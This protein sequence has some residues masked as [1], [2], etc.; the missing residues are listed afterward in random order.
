MQVRLGTWC[1]GCTGEPEGTVQWA[2][3][4]TTFDAAPYVMTITNL[5]ID[6]ANPAGS[7]IYSDMSGSDSSIATGGTIALPA[8]NDTIGAGAP[9]ASASLSQISVPAQSTSSAVA[10]SSAQGNSTTT[11]G[12]AASGTPTT[13]N[14]ANN[15]TTG[16]A[17]NVGPTA[18][19]L[20]NSEA[21]RTSMSG[22]A[23]L[24]LGAIILLAQ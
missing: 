2:G 1:G 22:F 11:S 10:S 12:S 18:T 4:P 23:L 9:S 8:G 6:N 24:V 15:T 3:G 13:T 5:E 17:F 19:T 20:P 16:S 21:A 7:Y 14:S